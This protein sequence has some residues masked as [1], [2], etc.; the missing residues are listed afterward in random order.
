MADIASFVVVFRETLEAAL[1][2]GIILAYLYKVK[3]TGFNKLVYAGVVAGILASIVA[4]LLFLKV[5]SGFE[6]EAEALFE[7]VAML[8]AAA[9]ITWMV[10]WMLKQR[11]TIRTETEKRVQIALD[12]G[13][14]IEL[15]LLPAIAVLRE[16]VETV[17]FLGA[18]SV[19]GAQAGS[20][21]LGSALGMG[22]A[23]LLGYLIFVAAKRINL[24]HFFTA[25]SIILI[26]LAAGLSAHGVHELQEASII[27]VVV[28]H[29]WDTNGIV[30]ENGALGSML[31]AMLGYN[32]NPSLLEV[33]SYAAYLSAVAILWRK[34]AK[35]KKKAA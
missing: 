12:N 5:A 19:A 16:G 3:Q 29:V 34:T 23:I 27:P 11:H 25:S 7:G 6:G 18:I 10:L 4:A 22:A 35:A 28:E 1:I 30:D 26:L 24:K 9:L 14:K 31:K 15:F 17:I 21:A 13:K 32:G 8:L 2:V 33:L 20:I